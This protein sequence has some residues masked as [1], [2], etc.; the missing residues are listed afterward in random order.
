M[1]LMMKIPCLLIN[2]GNVFVS[3]VVI[4][5]KKPSVKV[6][7]PPIVTSS[8]ITVFHQPDFSKEQIIEYND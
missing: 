2:A 7:T 5:Q 4:S 1:I 3:I 6:V 8:G